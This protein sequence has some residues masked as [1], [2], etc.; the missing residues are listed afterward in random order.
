MYH[1]DWLGCYWRQHINV[2]CRLFGCGADKK[3]QG[4]YLEKAFELYPAWK[5]IPDGELLDIGDKMIYGGIK[6]IKGKEIIELPDGT[7]E[8]I[9]YRYL[10]Y[11]K[12][13]DMYYGMTAKRGWEWFNSVREEE[14]FKTYIERAK[15]LMESE[16]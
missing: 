10:F 12:D 15:A 4:S 13:E 8:G 5:N 3:E 7:R 14:H 16:K 9:D 6:L 11:P 1:Q 2:A